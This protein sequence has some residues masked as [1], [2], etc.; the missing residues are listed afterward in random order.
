MM[1]FIFV[2]YVALVAGV[3]GV[4]I[5]KTSQ[6]LIFGIYEKPMTQGQCKHS[7]GE[8]WRLPYQPGPLGLLSTKIQ[9]HHQF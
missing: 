1:C 5:K 2:E 6:P 8:D 4:T 7:G 9:Q 3:G